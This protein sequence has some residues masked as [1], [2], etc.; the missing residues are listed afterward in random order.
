MGPR[1]I[2]NAHQELAGNL[3]TGEEEGL[4][5]KPDPVLFRQR[6]VASNPGREGPR[7]LANGPYPPGIFDDGV[8]LEAV[9]DDSG[10][11]QQPAPLCSSIAG[12]LVHHKAVEG[13]AQALPPF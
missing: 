3:A 1:Q 6:V 10:I 8:D 9:P 5:E 13:V 4:L 12:D 2:A 7:R 11:G